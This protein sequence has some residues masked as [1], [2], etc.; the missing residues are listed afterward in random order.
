MEKP[1]LPLEVQQYVDRLGEFLA[2]FF[3]LRE[4]KFIKGEICIL[5]GFEAETGNKDL[6]KIPGTNFNQNFKDR[7]YKEIVDTNETIE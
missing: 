5:L 6:I 4:I 1:E 7:I 3:E 2:H